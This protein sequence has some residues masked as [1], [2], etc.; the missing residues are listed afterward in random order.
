MDRDKKD[1]VKGSRGDCRKDYQS[2]KKV[3]ASSDA[4]KVHGGLGNRREEF[5]DGHAYD[6]SV[7]SHGGVRSDRKG[8]AYVDDVGIKMKSIKSGSHG[9]Q[10][11]HGGKKVEKGSEHR[12]GEE[13]KVE[14]LIDGKKESIR[15][16]SR[17]LFENSNGQKKEYFEEDLD[18]KDVK[19]NRDDEMKLDVKPKQVYEAPMPGSW[20]PAEKTNVPSWD[21][22]ALLEELRPDGWSPP[23]PTRVPISLLDCK[24]RFENETL[25]PPR[26]KIA[27]KETILREY[28]DIDEKE[29]LVLLDEDCVVRTNLRGI[30]ESRRMREKEE[31]EDEKE[32]RNA[33]REFRGRGGFG[34]RGRRGV[35]RGGRGSRED[36][37]NRGHGDQGNP[38]QYP[39]GQRSRFGDDLLS[40]ERRT[41]SPRDGR[42]SSNRDR[43]HPS[44]RDWRHPSPRDRRP[45]SPRDRRPS[46][47]KDRRPPSPR[48]KRPPSSKEGRPHSASSRQDGGKEFSSHHR[49]SRAEESS[50]CLQSEADHTSSSR[51]SYNPDHG[52]VPAHPTSSS[53]RT[54]PAPEMTYKEYKE[55]KA[56]EKAAGL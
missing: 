38:N 40:R 35:G 49:Q 1:E 19:L 41:D 28:R 43:R 25:E 22:E 6:R 37:S 7:K 34:G 48:E 24:E 4:S 50:R 51:W 26:V 11:P 27:D 3:G 13:D 21:P 23:T 8:E 44:P 46:S 32:Y 20:E 14:F 18:S 31:L 52:Q 45:L 36:R 5:H 15:N 53:S 47:P 30:K 2:D 55:R 16:E 17:S 54:A 12:V 56:R 42:P 10:L 29:P 33:R 9:I 39:V